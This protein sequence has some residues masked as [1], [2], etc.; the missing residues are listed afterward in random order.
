MKSNLD[1]FFKTSEDLEKNGV[2]FDISDE[3]GFLIRPFKASNPRVKAA[4]ALYYKPYARQIDLGTLELAKQQEINI[5]L[6][7]NVCL[8][9]W[10]GIEIDGQKADHGQ[11][12]AVKLFTLLPALF[13]T[14]WKHANDFSNY[15]EELGNS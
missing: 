4:L 5:K 1:S 2:W 8:V 14:L 11:E 15:K 6:F 9:D 12:N 7:V 13:D 10:K 3:V